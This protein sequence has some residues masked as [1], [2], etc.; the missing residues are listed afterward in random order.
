MS[1]ELHN[2][3]LV[4]QIQHQLLNLVL[5]SSLNPQVPQNMF[6][7]CKASSNPHVR[8]CQQH[9]KALKVHRIKA[10]KSTMMWK[11]FWV[12]SAIS[13]GSHARRVLHFLLAMIMLVPAHCLLSHAIF[14]PD[15][16]GGG[17]TLGTHCILLMRCECTC[18]LSI[19]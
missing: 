10:L 19:R 1:G 12:H 14:L 15:Q 17:F 6:R 16:A 5:E 7:E 13:C 18:Y 3:A 11:G 2:S 4:T 8:L 9:C